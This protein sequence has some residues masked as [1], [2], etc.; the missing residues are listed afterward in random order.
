MRLSQPIAISVLSLNAT[1]KLSNRATRE[2][3]EIPVLYEDAHLLILDKP[4]GLSVASDPSAPDRPGLVQLLHAGVAEGKSWAKERQL[5]YLRITHRLDA[6]ASGIAVFAR[7]KEVMVQLR[8]L[9]G[10][11]RPILRYLALVRGVPAGAE[12]SVE[13]KISPNA[14]RPGVSRIDSHHGKRSR[15]LI[16]GVETFLGYTLLAC[17]PLTDR[18]HQV[19]V[20]LRHAGFPVVGDQAYGGKPLWLSRLKKDYRLK[21]ERQERALISRPALHCEQ[22][23]L[24]HPVTGESLSVTAPWP[25]DM[26]VGL[27]YLRRYAAISAE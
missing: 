21:Q 15:T 20:H 18:A 14:H 19:R 3:W 16:K 24:P 12:F 5:T 13:A 1:I 7:A 11:E 2:F 22:A 10:I 6:E 27:K 26:E 23:S 25:K 17:E 8:E 4:S 9:F